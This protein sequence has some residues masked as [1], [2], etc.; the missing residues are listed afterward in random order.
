[1]L[2]QDELNFSILPEGQDTAGNDSAV[3]PKHGQKVRACCRRHR[4]CRW[5]GGGSWWYMVVHGGAC[6]RMRLNGGAGPGGEETACVCV[7]MRVRVRACTSMCWGRGPPRAARGSH[8]PLRSCPYTLP[9]HTRPRPLVHTAGGAHRPPRLPDGQDDR[10][11]RR[12]GQPDAARGRRTR[13]APRRP[14]HGQRQRENHLSAGGP[15][16]RPQQVQDGAAPARACVARLGIAGQGCPSPP[17]LAACGRHAPSAP[18][19]PL[20]ALPP[21]PRTCHP[22]VPRPTAH[23]G[24]VCCM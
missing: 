4:R 22:C 6:R 7:R 15:R 12:A 18:P 2:M 17:A 14:R 8:L 13:Q 3:P 23:T 16:L 5:R 11:H 19:P 20:D 9:V 10:D 1:M 24:R 21:P